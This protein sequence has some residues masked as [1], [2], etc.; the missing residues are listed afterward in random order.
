LEVAEDADA[1]YEL[2]GRALAVPGYREKLLGDREDKI[3]ALRDAG[4][5]HPDQ[6]MIDKLDAAIFALGELRNAFGPG[7]EAP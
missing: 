4:V 1:F 2:F 7:P 3:A 6:K 5:P